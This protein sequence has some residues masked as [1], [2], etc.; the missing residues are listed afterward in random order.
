MFTEYA[1]PLSGLI[2]FDSQ[3]HYDDEAF[4]PDRDELLAALPQQGI[5]GVINCGSD[6]AS[7]ET[8]LRLAESYP[9][10]Y[11]AVGVHP[12]EAAA[13]PEDYLA[14]ISRLAAHPKA[15]AIGEIGLDYHY[16]FSP[17]EVQIFLLSAQLRLA[18]ELGLPV[19][20]HDREAHSDMI[21]LLEKYRP[22]GVVHC[23]SGSVELAERTLRL[24]MYI[25]LGGAVTFKNARKPVEVARM[26]PPDRLLLE[27][28]APYMTPVPFRG[29]RCDSTCIPI[30]AEAIAGIRGISRDELLLQ[31]KKNTETLFRI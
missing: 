22:R 27:T 7:S 20:L 18:N 10:I 5:C 12:H 9:Y 28:D 21:E 23:F 31:C 3:A 19:I 17:R 8:S 4:D 6:L 29:K 16:D 11:A 14:R 15:V 26:V 24:G 2:V 1:K 30:T 25:G 13:V